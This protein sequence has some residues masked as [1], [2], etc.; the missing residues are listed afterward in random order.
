MANEGKVPKRGEFFAVDKRCW[1]AAIEVGLNPAVAYL[2]LASFSGRNQKSTAASSEAVRKH[3]AIS[4]QRAKLAIASLISA[5]LLIQT[6]GGSK[7][8]Y[9][10]V[11]WK[12]FAKLRTGHKLAAPEWLWLP[13]SH[14]CGAAGE[15]PPVARVRQTQD[16][17]TL[18]LLVDLY[19]EQNLVED[20]G[21]SRRL[22]WQVY[23]RKKLWERGRYVVWGF[24]AGELTTARDGVLL[25]KTHGKE[26]WE[27]LDQ[28][29]S[30]GLV[31]W[32]QMVWESDSAEAEPMFPISGE[33][34]DD[35]GAQIGLAAYEASEALMADAEWEPNYHPMVPLPKHL[36]NVQLIGIARLRYR[37]KTK[38]T[39]A[40]HAQHE[41]NGAR[42]LEIYEALSEGRRPGMPTQA[43]AYV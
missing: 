12:E 26:I 23:R 1:H 40:W 16:K 20:G 28:L 24:S 22:L 32:I 14:V 35:L 36:G 18:R 9:T 25:Y 6:K 31:T 33:R 13:N 5:G 10:I 29:V 11:P 2:V 7:P 27:R 34:E 19:E 41:Q 15:V 37:P 4:W 8:R 17:M 21:S 43:D 38:L 39:G 42:W 3:A 30:L